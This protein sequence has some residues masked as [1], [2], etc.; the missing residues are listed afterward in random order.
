MDTK[1]YN[2]IV[3]TAKLS[4]RDVLRAE[5]ISARQTKISNLE[6]ERENLT[7]EA[8]DYLARLKK[9]IARNAYKLSKL[10]D[11]NPDA[12][13]IK[14]YCKTDDE[15]SN[16]EIERTTKQLAEETEA[17][18]KMITEQKE[19]I[20]KIESGETKVSLARLNEIA[21]NFVQDAVKAGFLKSAEAVTKT[22][23]S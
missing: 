5:L 7:K 4:A 18:N 2:T 6:T 3:A 23:L 14:K 19:G 1:N 21:N 13:D 11:A 8:N 16:K 17:I 12:E 10:E 9:D 22:K 15:F 20:A